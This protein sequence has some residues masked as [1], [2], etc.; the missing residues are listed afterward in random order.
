MLEES[1]YSQNYN[2]NKPKPF[3][4]LG[5]VFKLI[6]YIFTPSHNHFLS[7]FEPSY[8]MMYFPAI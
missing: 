4:V 3:D 7:L 1:D 5:G 8:S 2:P 6:F